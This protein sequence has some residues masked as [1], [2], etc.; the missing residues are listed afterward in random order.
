MRKARAE[1]APINLWLIDQ[2]RHRG[3]RVEDVATRLDVSPSTVR[4]W[5][6]GRSIS[7]D[8]IARLEVVFGVKA[9]TTGS[10]GSD[11]PT[12]ELV[13]LMARQ[14]EA[15]ERQAIAQE[16]TA[17]LL[18]QLIGVLSGQVLD[19]GLQSWAQERLAESIGSPRPTPDHEPT[20]A[21]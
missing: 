3:W 11:T 20:P 18:E 16:R 4:G 2:T 13:A 8:N 5:E 9:P 10:A 21:R 7:P 15:A 19:A 12:A 17:N 6:A 14:V 1:K